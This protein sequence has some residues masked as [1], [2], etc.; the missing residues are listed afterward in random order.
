MRVKSLLIV[1]TIFALLL[2]LGSCSRWGGVDNPTGPSEVRPKVY[3]DPGTVNI[4]NGLSFPVKVFLEN[5]TN[6]YYAA[7]DVIY[8]TAKVSL[9]ENNWAEG[10]FLKQDG[11]N[12]QFTVGPEQIITG[13]LAK[14]NI[15]VVRL[16][17]LGGVSGSGVLC[18]FTFKAT[19]AGTASID[20]NRDPNTLGFMG[21]DESRQQYPIEITVDHGTIVNIN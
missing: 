9:P 16:G 6:L 19:A 7:F 5:A 17:S 11:A 20:F 21:I 14:R 8:D 1:V 13:T 18:S 3:M 2:P 15:G 12:I 4:N 10:P